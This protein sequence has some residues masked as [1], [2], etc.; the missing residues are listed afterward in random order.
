MPT[1]E[2]LHKLIE[3][4]P[5][6]AMETAYSAL[7]R[8]QVWP[9]PPP[10][11]TVMKKRFED[12][13]LE[14]RLRLEARLAQRAGVIIGSGSKAGYEATRGS[15]SSSMDQWEG[16]TYVVHTY[17]H[18]QGHEIMVAERLAVDGKRLIYKHEVTGPGNKH[19]ERES[20]FEL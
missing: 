5:D 19:D 9:P 15:G 6:G 18:H 12:K 4:M 11:I 13:R 16:D 20:V 3:S 14:M 10:D 7:Y 8:L 1:R 2:E 17:R